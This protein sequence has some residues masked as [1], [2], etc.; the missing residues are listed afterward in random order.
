MK[1]IYAAFIVI[2]L[3][4]VGV[5]AATY[6]LL[7][8]T[9]KVDGITLA[10]GNADIQISDDSLN[11]VEDYPVSDSITG[12]VP[13]YQSPTINFHLKNNGTVDLHVTVRLTHADDDWAALKDNVYIHV[14]SADTGIDHDFTLAQWNSTD[15]DL[16]NLSVG[17]TAEYSVDVH[18][19]SSVGN[20]IA[21]KQIN[22]VTFI[23][24]GTQIL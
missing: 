15:R 5:G 7:S 17:S 11:F 24:T 6:A 1:R 12:L 9:A 23:V 8:D 21:N 14:I 13:G 10:T 19:P 4:A 16:G 20:E 2:I 3:L 18:V 22:N